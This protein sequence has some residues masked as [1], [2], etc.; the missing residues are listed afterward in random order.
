[1]S[2]PADLSYLWAASGPGAL[3]IGTI[4]DASCEQP[5]AIF[6]RGAWISATRSADPITPE[7]A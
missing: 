3:V 7:V 2:S 4:D 6:S 1:M 5:V